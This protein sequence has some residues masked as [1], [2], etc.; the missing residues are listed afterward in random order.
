MK[1]KLIIFALLFGAVS[2]TIE[3]KAQGAEFEFPDREEW[4]DWRETERDFDPG[5][6]DG[7]C[8]EEDD[9]SLAPKRSDDTITMMTYNVWHRNFKYIDSIPRYAEVISFINPDV[10]ALQELRGGANFEA[11]KIATGMRGEM[12]NTHNTT[13]DDIGRKRNG[14]GIM[15]KPSLDTPKITT[16]KL[17]FGEQVAY[18]VAEFNNFCFVCTHYPVNVKP[19]ILEKW[20]RRRT[21]R[22]ILNNNAVKNCIKSG[23][24]VYI[25]GDFNEAPDDANGAIQL[26]VDAGFEVLNDVLTYPYTYPT[27]VKQAPQGLADMIIEYNRNPYRELIETRIPEFPSEAHK[28]LSDHYPYVVKVKLK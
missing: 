14:I 7:Q 20:Y 17:P 12:L 19:E 27:P 10:I 26:F 3:I 28:K 15:W 9:S 23:K 4:S 24:P 1:K 11:L 22:N 16:K 25:G 18:M 6:D 8:D 5:W 13:E 21:T 2:L